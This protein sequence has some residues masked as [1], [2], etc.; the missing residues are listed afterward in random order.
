MFQAPL[1]IPGIEYPLVI[2]SI[3][4]QP[5]ILLSTQ[6]LPLHQD[7]LKPLHHKC[8]KITCL[9]YQERKQLWLQEHPNVL[10]KDYRKA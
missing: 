2:S 1:L 6:A 9:L 10:P 8:I 4:E 3:R 7:V 5:Q